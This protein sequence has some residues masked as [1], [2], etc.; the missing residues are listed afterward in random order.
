MSIRDDAMQM[1]DSR[2]HVPSF[3]I[4]VICGAQGYVRRSASDGGSFGLTEF[5]RPL[6]TVKP[7]NRSLEIELPSSI[8]YSVKLVVRIAAGLQRKANLCV[9]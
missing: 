2:L 1:L 4:A 7:V 8:R 5:S 3:R 9:V 6:H